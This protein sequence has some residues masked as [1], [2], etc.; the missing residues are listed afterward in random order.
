MQYEYNIVQFT[1][2]LKGGILG[3]KGESIESQFQ[4]FVNGNTIDNWEYYRMDTVHA[5]V[6]AGCLATIFGR[7][8][9]VVYQDVAVFRRE[10][11]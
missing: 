5:Y 6:K 2:Q 3:A 7:K 4:K 10:K 8:D 9:E 1:A 11:K